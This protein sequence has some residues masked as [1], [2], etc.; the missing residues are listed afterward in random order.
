MSGLPLGLVLA[1][2]VA[3]AAALSALLCMTLGKLIMRQTRIVAV[4][5]CGFI[6]PI[7]IVVLGLVAILAMGSPGSQSVTML[8]AML[9]FWTLPICLLTS[10]A[11]IAW[12]AQRGEDGD[13]G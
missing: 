11:M 7:A 9:C 8:T 12:I 3:G 4:L 1:A 5:I 10:G 6:P 13:A 2:I